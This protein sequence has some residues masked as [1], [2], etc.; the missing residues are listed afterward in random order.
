VKFGP[1]CKLALIGDGAFRKCSSIESVAIPDTVEDLGMGCFEACQI[2]KNVGFSASSRLSE[3]GDRAF[4]NCQN[5]KRIDLPDGV[6]AIGDQCFEC[7]RGLKSVKFMKD[8]HRPRRWGHDA[9]RK[10]PRLECFPSSE[11]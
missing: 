8:T 5:I 7:C 10:C 4:Q 9:F 6:E 2:L 11:D 1:S 3:I